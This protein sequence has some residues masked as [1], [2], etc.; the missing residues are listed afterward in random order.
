MEFPMTYTGPRLVYKFRADSG[1]YKTIIDRYYRQ[2]AFLL[3]PPVQ[4]AI[5]SLAIVG[6][7]LGFK[8]LFTRTAVGL[9]MVVVALLT[10]GMVALTKASVFYRFK[11]RADFGADVIMTVSKESISSSG[12]HAEGKWGWQA[13]PQSVR[14]PDGIL[15]LRRGVIRWLPDSALQEG[16]P[17][18]ATA[19]VKAKTVMKALG[20]QKPGTVPP[21]Q[22]INGVETTQIA[23]TILQLLGLSPRWLQ[24]VQMEGTQ[25]LP[26]LRDGR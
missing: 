14:Y 26:G 12:R 4:Y 20:H 7:F 24:A 15:L 13:Y 8:G 21:G 3:R 23:P 22:S 16:T 18:D 6:A 9:G 5:F 10:A 2:R 25:V 1:Y 11:R 19:L 17:A